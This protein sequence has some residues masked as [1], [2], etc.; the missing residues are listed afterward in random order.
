MPNWCSNYIVLKGSVEF[1]DAFKEAC[2]LPNENGKKSAF[3]FFQTVPRPKED[4]NWY[5]W[6][7]KHWGTKW[8]AR[9]PIVMFGI[10][11]VTIQCETAWS[12]PKKWAKNYFNSLSPELQE[13]SEILIAYCEMGMGFYGTMKISKACVKSKTYKMTDD[14][15][16][17]EKDENGNE[18]EDG[19]WDT[20]KIDSQFGQFLT[21]YCLR[22]YGG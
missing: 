20:P 14:D 3:S 21:Q 4:D 1:I 16:T 8:D 19:C 15:W 18:C 22:S 11:Q 5:E 9:D 7:A 10:N 13:R 17:K 12:P 6:N 2:E